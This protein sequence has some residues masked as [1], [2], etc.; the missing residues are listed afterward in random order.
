M[1]IKKKSSFFYLFFLIVYLVISVPFVNASIYEDFDTYDE[2]DLDD[3]LNY[4]SYHIDLYAT[5]HTSDQAYLTYNYGVNFFKNFTHTID[6]KS[7]FYATY[8]LGVC[9]M[10]A[11]DLGDS[12][13]L[14][15]NNKTYIAIQFYK[16]TASLRKIRLTEAYN[17]SFFLDTY[18]CSADTWY[19]FTII[20]TGKNLTCNIY[21]NSNRSTLVDTLY[22]NLHED[23]NFQYVYGCCT[24]SGGQA[25]QYMNID[26]ENLNLFGANFHI[27]F[28]F[29]EG[30]IFM[31]NKTEI[32]N[33]T[34]NI[35]VNGTILEFLASTKNYSYVFY[36]YTWDSNNS[37]DNPYDFTVNANFTI[38]CYFSDTATFYDYTLPIALLISFVLIIV[39]L[40]VAKRK[41]KR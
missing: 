3:N 11:N 38:W 32:T 20:K 26:V 34:T 18:T 28:Y 8:S 7:D 22:L 30:G 15:L 14:V 21:S 4:T 2:T 6:A 40:Y 9:Y 17:S 25:S 35:Y 37:T 41:I 33:G 12:R 10:L 13:N 27:T 24:Y 5:R 39:L 19:Y 36:N 23:H 31:I 1:T 16:Q 29:N